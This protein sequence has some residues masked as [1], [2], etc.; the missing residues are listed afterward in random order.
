MTIQ[1]LELGGLSSRVYG[2]LREALIGGLFSPGERIVM[3]DLA[4]R[5]GV[6]VTPVREACL[7]LV[8]ENGLEIRGGRNIMVPDL[9]LAR[10]LEIRMIRMALEGMAAELAAVNA[11][12][13][14]VRR[15]ADIQERF[16]Q[17]RHV[18]D[19][20]TAGTANREFHFGVYQLSRREL[21][22]RQIETMWVSMGPILKVYHEE[23]STDYLDADEHVNLISAL[24]AHDGKAARHALLRDLERGGEGILR[25]LSMLQ[26][27]RRALVQG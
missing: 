18:R 25:H 26:E 3:Q 17:A 2:V 13:D 1:P 4:E 24:A 23:V 16:E 7:R 6:S 21:L 22:V 14:D 27:A 20:T 8:S 9:D 5:L 12:H 19:A 11:T 15:L 10:Y